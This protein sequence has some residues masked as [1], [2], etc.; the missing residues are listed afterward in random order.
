MLCFGRDSTNCHYLIT[1]TNLQQMK[2]LFSVL[3]VVFFASCADNLE[4]PQPIIYDIGI[5]NF[6]VGD[7]HN[8]L[9]DVFLENMTED[10]YDI[11]KHTAE[12]KNILI[13]KSPKISSDWGL[14][15]QEFIKVIKMVDFE[16]LIETRTV[17]EMGLNMINESDLSINFKHKIALFD[18]LISST[19][20][21][22]VVEKDSQV[23]KAFYT[24]HEKDL[25]LNEKTLFENFIDVAIKSNKFWKDSDYGGLNGRRK[26][27]SLTNSITNK[28]QLQTRWNPFKTVMTDVTCMVGAAVTSV[29]ATGGASAIPNPLLGG[30]PTASAIAVVAGAVGSL[31]TLW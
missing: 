5:R 20:Q 31:N 19:S 6:E 21:T 11:T 25:K 8:Y 24:R 18:V 2:K 23:F 12:L 1:I 4:S 15:N 16:K 3:M 29:I 13:E 30:L 7:F 14:D 9:L 10:P 27:L 22:E 17:R 28:I 26:G